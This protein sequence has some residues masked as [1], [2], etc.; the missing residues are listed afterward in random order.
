[1]PPRAV[2]LSLEAEHEA[3]PASTTQ[4]FDDADLSAPRL[5]SATL[6]C[7][8]KTVQISHN[9]FVYKLQA[10]KLGKLILTK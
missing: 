8:Q 10:T 9:G 7:G 1:M 6:L 2:P 5:D 3:R 4:R